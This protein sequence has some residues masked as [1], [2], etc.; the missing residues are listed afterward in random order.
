[1]QKKSYLVVGHT[2]FIGRKLVDELKKSKSN[3]YLVSRKIKK[4][5]KI[6]NEFSHDVF[7]DFSWFKYLTNNM[8]V[9]FLA[10][11]NNLYELE[12]DKHYLNQIVIFCTKFNEHI[13]RNNLRINLIFTSTAT[14]YGITNSKQ[15]VN[16]NFPNNPISVYDYS[17]LLFEKI[18]QYFSVE[19]NIKFVSLRLTNIYGYHFVRKQ[20]N[21][22]FLNKL[23][24]YTMN[25]K[26]IDI[27]G[28]GLKKRSYLY[29]D[30]LIKALI[31]TENKIKKLKSKEILV[32][33]D[34]SHSFNEVL[35]IISKN[36]D[37]KMKIKKKKYTKKTHSIEKR[38]FIGNNNFFKKKTGWK[39]SIKLHVGI[40]KIIKQN[41]NKI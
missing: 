24:Y 21:R 23:I 35:S 38:S 15:I 17:K 32:C 40:N 34:D 18:F 5:N 13:I 16:E 26:N 29:I 3:L 8:T 7:N 36:L 41:L 30:D 37:V 39:P 6:R 12:K 33:G 20:K 27:L 9:F 14:I 19:S 22:G 11:N 25:K 31:I 2:G 1:M 10:Y 28:S 4:E